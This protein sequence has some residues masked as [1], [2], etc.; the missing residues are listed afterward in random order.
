MDADLQFMVLILK[1]KMSC[2][3]FQNLA[4]RMHSRR[5]EIL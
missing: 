5:Y 4:Y 1:F 2:L 3:I